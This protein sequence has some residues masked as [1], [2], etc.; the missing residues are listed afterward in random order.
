MVWPTSFP[1]ACLKEQ[2]IPHTHLENPDHRFQRT[3]IKYWN[4]LLITQ[5][6][7]DALPERGLDV[8]SSRE[9]PNEEGQIDGVHAL[10]IHPHQ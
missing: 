8:P 3:A 5:N 4:E 9:G 1:G 2:N 6:F 10:R 7:A